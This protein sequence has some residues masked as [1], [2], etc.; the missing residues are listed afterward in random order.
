MTSVPSTTTTLPFVISQVTTNTGPADLAPFTVPAGSKEW[1][2]DWVYDCSSTGGTGTFEIKVIGY[3][4]AA[5]TTD[6][7]VTQSGT[8]TS[9]ISRNY[10]T[11]KFSLNVSTPCKWTVRVEVTA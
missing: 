3:G 5:S 9:G 11:G 10:D 2:I 1:D 8:G 6:V 4:S 7:G